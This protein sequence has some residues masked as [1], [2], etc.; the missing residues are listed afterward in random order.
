MARIL[1]KAAREHRYVD[2]QKVEEILH[3]K[4]DGMTSKPEHVEC[5]QSLETEM[6]GNY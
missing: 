6:S 3:V 1:Y 5:G 4:P 2:Q